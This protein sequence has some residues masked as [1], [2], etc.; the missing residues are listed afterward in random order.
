[1]A[2]TEHI[3]LTTQ[4]DEGSAAMLNTFAVILS[5]IC[6]GFKVWCKSNS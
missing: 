6:N 4:V 2:I 1:M 5:E 3:H